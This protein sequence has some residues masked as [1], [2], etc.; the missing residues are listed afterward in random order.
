MLTVTEKNSLL[1]QA[2]EITKAFATKGAALTIP[3]CL[4]ETY[5]QLKKLKEDAKKTEEGS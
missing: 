5:N 2:V 3:A 1:V 4:K